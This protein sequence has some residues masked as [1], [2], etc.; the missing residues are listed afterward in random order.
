MITN[1]MVE[2]E[3][4][5]RANLILNSLIDRT[6]SESVGIGL[7]YGRAGLGKT[8]WGFKTAVSKGYIYLR[9]IENMTVKDFLKEVLRALKYKQNDMQRQEEIIGTQK[10]IYEQVLEILQDKPDTVIIFDEIDYAFNKPRILATIR[11]FA[12][13]CVCTFALIGM[14]NAKSQLMKLNAHYFDRCNGFYEFTPLTFEDVEKIIQNVCDCDVDQDLVKFIHKKSN[15]T[16]RLINKYIEALEKLCK[17]KGVAALKYD[18]VK[19]IMNYE[20]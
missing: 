4:V 18:D 7:F 1:Q 6:R 17:K 19:G 12:D 15:G 11:D 5:R 2:I 16:L 13:Q 9:L 3:N 8:R 14:Q 10:Q 20:L